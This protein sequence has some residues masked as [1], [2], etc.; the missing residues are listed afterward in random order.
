M[1]L[2]VATGSPDWVYAIAASRTTLK[3]EPLFRLLAIALTAKKLSQ[4]L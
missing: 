4:W 2:A 1:I 3:V